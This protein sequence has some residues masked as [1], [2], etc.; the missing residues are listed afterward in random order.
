MS[1]P[2]P[3]ATRP[4][5]CLVTVVQ[6]ILVIWLLTHVSEVWHFLSNLIR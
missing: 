3:V 2:T 5:G 6:F 4:F 1:E